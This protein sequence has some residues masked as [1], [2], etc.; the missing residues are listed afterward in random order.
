MG[1]RLPLVNI[2]FLNVVFN[3]LSE[4][5]MKWLAD[6]GYV[7][8]SEVPVRIHFATDFVVETRLPVYFHEERGRGISVAFER[9]NVGGAMTVLYACLV[10]YEDK[11]IEASLRITG[12]K[13]IIN[14]YRLAHL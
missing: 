3:P 6:N 9:V 8:Y 14:P 1:V 4:D 5:A 13:E 7:D 11:P 2:P 10:D 12:D